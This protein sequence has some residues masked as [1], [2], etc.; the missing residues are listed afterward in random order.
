[1][2]IAPE[3]TSGMDSEGMIIRRKAPRIEPTIVRQMNA[4]NRFLGRTLPFRKGSAPPK[5][6]KIRANMFVATAAR[7]SNPNCSMTGTV[8][9]D[10][11]PVTTLITAVQKNTATKHIHPNVVIVGCYGALLYCW[12]ATSRLEQRTVLYRAT[13]YTV[14]RQRRSMQQLRLKSAQE[15]LVEDVS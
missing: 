14:E 7:G 1:M 15:G 3:I 2:I 9:R 12:S 4:G 8:T 10:V 5:L 13:R 6:R 11:L